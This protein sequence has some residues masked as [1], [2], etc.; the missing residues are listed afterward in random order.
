MKS[1]AVIL[2]M[3]LPFFVA[4]QKNSVMYFGPNGKME[5]GENQLIKKEIQH[6]SKRNVRIATYKME[7]NSWKLLFSERITVKNPQTHN[8][9]IKG[10]FFR[11]RITRSFEKQP[12]SVFK[13]TDKQGE[14]VKRTGYT[15]S[16][17]PL[18]FHGEVTEFYS[19]GQKK[20]VSVYENNELVSNQNWTEEGDE[21]IND[22]FYSVNREPRYKPGTVRFHQHVLKTFQESNLD[23]SQLEGRL[24]VGFVVMENGEIDGVRI[25][26][27]MGRELNDLALQA[28]YSLPGEWQ[29]AQLNGDDVRYYQLFPINFI[30]HQFDFDYL[31]MRGSMLYWSIN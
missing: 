16:K 6:R 14:T 13:F 28:I 25:E 31:E 12:G 30:Y 1:F 17:I 27:G 8:I 29:P 10:D 4:G 21:Y 2:F 19:G 5:P 3:I 24:V 26:Q 9:R 18:I 11:E 15:L 7:E 23:I 22:V 20:S